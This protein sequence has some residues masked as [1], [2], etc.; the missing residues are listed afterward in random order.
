M[1]N[2]LLINSSDSSSSLRIYG[3]AGDSEERD[4]EYF[5]VEVKSF[6]FQA[7]RRVYSHR[8]A[9]SLVSLFEW[10]A[11]NWKGWSGNRSWSSVEGEFSLDCS[12][13]NLGHIHLD[14]VIS[15]NNHSE[16][17]KIEARIN[18]DAEQLS[19]IANQ[20]RLLVGN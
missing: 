7:M 8:D 10:M 20:A 16:P 9:V 15:D 19:A 5:S 1:E 2:E 17:W 3:L 18:I 11:D 4:S 14:V 12:S 13:D 6:Q